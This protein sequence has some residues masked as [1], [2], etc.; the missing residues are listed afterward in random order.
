MGNVNHRKPDPAE[1]NHR[2]KVLELEWRERKSARILQALDEAAVRLKARFAGYTS[3]TIEK[4]DRA[5]ILRISDDREL[6]LYLELN[7]DERGQLSQKFKVR[8]RQI[9]RRPAYEEVDQEHNFVTLEMAVEFL[10]R[11]CE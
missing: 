3:V 9:R 1:T 5:I 8:D 11:A 6:K 4:G 10:V 7:F 2:L